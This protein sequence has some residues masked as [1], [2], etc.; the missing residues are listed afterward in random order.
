MT[1]QFLIIGQ[2]MHW[3]SLCIA[4]TCAWS[5]IDKRLGKFLVIPAWENPSVS[6]QSVCI[7]VSITSSDPGHMNVQCIYSHVKT[8]DEAGIAP[9][10]LNPC[11]LVTTL[12]DT[13]I[14]KASGTTGMPS[15]TYKNSSAFRYRQA[16]AIAAMRQQ[17][18]RK[19]INVP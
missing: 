19:Q 17:V 7:Q 1:Q 16:T 18:T 12:K 8:S 11:S 2:C 13:P 14:P 15:S 9:C 4:R 6:V 3:C 10:L 5:G